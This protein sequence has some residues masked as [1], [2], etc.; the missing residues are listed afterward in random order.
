ML[1]AVGEVCVFSSTTGHGK[2]I[3]LCYSETNPASDLLIFYFGCHISSVF[4]GD[5]LTLFVWVN[6]ET[7]NWNIRSFYLVVKT[8]PTKS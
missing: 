7:L 4:I 2:S 5:D 3:K 1:H 8:L 6:C